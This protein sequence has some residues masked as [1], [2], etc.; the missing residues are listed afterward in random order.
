M[1]MKS[2]TEA[3]LTATGNLLLA[4]RGKES[5]HSFRKGIDCSPKHMFTLAKSSLETRMLHKDFGEMESF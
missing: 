2:R 5:I 1:E 3:A 4:T